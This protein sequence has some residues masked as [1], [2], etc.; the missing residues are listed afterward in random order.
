MRNVH[1]ENK[2][3]TTA[4][5]RG[6]GGWGAGGKNVLLWLSCLP[7][8]KVQSSAVRHAY[9][10]CIGRQRATVQSTPSNYY[11]FTIVYTTGEPPSSA[12][13]VK[14][15]IQGTKFRV[16]KKEKRKRENKREATT[17]E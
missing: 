2:K 17:D 10:F 3:K 6:G 1:E 14:S 16:G 9:D 12:H 11:R 8:V 7:V 15:S 13:E 4:T 5:T